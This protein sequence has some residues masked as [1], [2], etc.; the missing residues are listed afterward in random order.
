MLRKLAISLSIS[1]VVFACPTISP[2]SSNGITDCRLANG[3]YRND[4][5]FVG[6]QFYLFQRRHDGL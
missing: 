2:F 6:F 1:A 4:L 3:R 5:H